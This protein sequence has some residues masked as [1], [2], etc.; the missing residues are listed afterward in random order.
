VLAKP[1]NRYWVTA[2]FTGDD[3][4]PRVVELDLDGKSTATILPNVACP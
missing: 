4:E 3:F 2:T 1:P